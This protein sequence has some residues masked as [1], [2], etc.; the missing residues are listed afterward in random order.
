M[1]LT[2]TVAAK[3]VLN[4]L[5]QHYRNSF[6]NTLRHG[7]HQV[8]LASA[9]AGNVNGGGDW[10]DDRL[11]PDILRAIEAEQSVKIRNPQATRPWQHVLEPLNGYLLLAEKLYTKRLSIC[12]GV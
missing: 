4:W 11:I 5:P 9:R 12:G 2:L 1:A 3:V 10:A 8:A 6:F 7:E